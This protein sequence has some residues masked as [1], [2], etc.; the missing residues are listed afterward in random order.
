MKEHYKLILKNRIKYVDFF[1]TKNTEKF[2][3]LDK[4]RLTL[5]V[6]STLGYEMISRNK[7][8]NNI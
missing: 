8:D 6:D 5:T 4:F 2:K 1:I 3:F 7:K